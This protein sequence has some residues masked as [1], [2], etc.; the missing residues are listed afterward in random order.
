MA[1]TSRIGELGVIDGT[2]WS[3]DPDDPNPFPFDMTLSADDLK[4][5]DVWTGEHK[6]FLVGFVVRALMRGAPACR[7]RWTAS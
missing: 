3:V 6:Q 1:N 4:Q 5:F 2:Y 7:A